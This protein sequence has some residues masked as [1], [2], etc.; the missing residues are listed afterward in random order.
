[1]LKNI[2]GEKKRPAGVSEEKKREKRPLFE[3]ALWMGV[4]RRASAEGLIPPPSTQ[5]TLGKKTHSPEKEWKKHQNLLRTKEKGDALIPSPV[6]GQ[7]RRRIGIFVSTVAG[8]QVRNGGKG[9]GGVRNQNAGEGGGQLWSGRGKKKES[10]MSC[11][12][13]AMGEKKKKKEG[14]SVALSVGYRG[15]AKRE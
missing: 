9:K 13:V 10:T 7:R 1:M 14:G 15:P 4:G 5:R 3:V 8:A 6:A 11:V 2:H 12:V